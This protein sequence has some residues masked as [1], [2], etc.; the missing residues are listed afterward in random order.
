MENLKRK[1]IQFMRGRYGADQLYNALIISGMVLYFLGAMTDVG[2]LVF[3]A[4]ILIFLGA[5][6]GLFEKDL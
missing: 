5:V 4:Q 1:M 6:P 3:V 2:V